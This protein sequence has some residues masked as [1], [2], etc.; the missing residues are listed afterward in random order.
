VDEVL[1]DESPARSL[2]AG[3]FET[4]DVQPPDAVTRI[5]AQQVL[6]ENRYARHD[7]RA[8]S[9]GLSKSRITLAAALLIIV[10]VVG[11]VL[12]K[13]INRSSRD[14]K[15]VDAISTASAPL[16][17]EKLTGTGRSAAV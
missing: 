1:T 16:K 13:F 3:P 8:A 9:T 7:S 15:R 12:L 4:V 14:N 10:G 11:F 5:E 6:T 2:T 17:L